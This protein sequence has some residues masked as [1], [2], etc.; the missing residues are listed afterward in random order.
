M[1]NWL[2]TL[3][4]DNDLL[5]AGRMYETVTT[6]RS[7]KPRH[8]GILVD[9]FGNGEIHGFVDTWLVCEATNL[10]DCKQFLVN[11]SPFLEG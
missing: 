9:H 8:L 11:V 5:P 1:D 6:A 7:G 3:L 2:E 10:E 4:V